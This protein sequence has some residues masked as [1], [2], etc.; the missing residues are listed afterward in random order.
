MLISLSG[1]FAALVGAASSPTRFLLVDF[2]SG[3]GG[4]GGVLGP[5]T[6]LCVEGEEE[7]DATLDLEDG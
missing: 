3:G 6:A 5:A 7:E 4:G 1:I 2:M